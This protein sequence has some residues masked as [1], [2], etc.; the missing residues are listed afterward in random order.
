MSQFFTMKMRDGSI[1][2]V[3]VYLIAENRAAHYASEFGGSLE[4]SLKEDTLPLFAQSQYEISDWAINN[5][6]WSDFA[7]QHY[8]MHDATPLTDEEFQDAWMSADKHIEDV[9]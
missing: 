6:N 2:G 3:P 7:G 8:K 5:M 1:W 9:S 4:R